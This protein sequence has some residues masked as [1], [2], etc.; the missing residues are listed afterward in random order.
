MKDNTTMKLLIQD[1]INKIIH[2]TSEC[3]STIVEDIAFLSVALTKAN[4]SG[5]ISEEEARK[6]GSNFKEYRDLFSKR[7]KCR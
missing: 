5:T 7:C 2:K 1:N 6:F 4:Q 3:D